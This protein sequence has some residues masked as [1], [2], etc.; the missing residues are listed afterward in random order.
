MANAYGGYGEIKA[1]GVEAGIARLESVVTW[2]RSSRQRYSRLRFAGWLAEGHLRRGDREQA[3]PLIEDVLNTSRANGYRYL[4]GLAC[5]LMAV[6]MAPEAP[7]AAADYADEAIR[8]L[9]AI[10]ARNDLAKAIMTR[11]AS[12]QDFGDAAKA[13]RLSN[14]A[15]AIFQDLGTY[16]E[17]AGSTLK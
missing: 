4:E 10:G 8:I 16:G 17:S 13:E 3:A 12:W 11:A 9:D 7:A 14:E 15:A 6:C 1:G 5:W 2:L